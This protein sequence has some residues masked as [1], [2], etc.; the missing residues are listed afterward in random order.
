MSQPHRRR[1]RTTPPQS[2][3]VVASSVLPFLEAGGFDD[4]DRQSW[5]TFDVIQ[6]ELGAGTVDTVSP[7]KSPHRG[8]LK[9]SMYLLR[10]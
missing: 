5:Q 1:T 4:P 7:K 2:V 8:L 10:K 6:V 3:V 9:Q